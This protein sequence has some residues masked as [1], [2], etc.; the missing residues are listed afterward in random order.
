MLQ[1]GL[2]PINPIK[3]KGLSKSKSCKNNSAI[4]IRVKDDSNKDKDVYA[5]TFNK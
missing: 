2:D 1:A 4:S 5:N 3:N